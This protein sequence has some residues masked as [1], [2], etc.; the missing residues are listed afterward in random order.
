MEPQMQAWMIEPRDGLSFRDGRPNVGG[1]ESQSLRFPLPQTIAGAVRSRAGVDTE[2]R[3]D[4][5]QRESV[6]QLTIHGPLLVR[7]KGGRRERLVQAPQDALWEEDVNGQKKLH[8]LGPIQHDPRLR[9]GTAPEG[10][11]LVGLDVAPKG[12]PPKD[13][14]AFWTWEHLMAWLQSP[15]RAAGDLV[16]EIHKQGLGALVQEERVS[17]SIDPETNTYRHG[18]LFGVTSLLFRTAAHRLEE[19]SELGLCF[20][21][22]AKL[23]PGFGYLGGKNKL[24]TFSQEDS[25]EWP[26]TCPFEAELAKEERLRVLLLT[27]GIFKEGWSPTRLLEPSGGL[28]PIL[29]AAK[30]DRPETISGWDYEHQQTKGTRRLVGAG[31][32][33]WL[34]LGGTEEQRRQWIRDWWMQPVSDKDEDCRDGFGLAVMGVWA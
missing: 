15:A 10:L 30:V 21:T 19:V 31:A 9:G 14:P 28:S 20:R 22:D 25:P 2:G 17:V 4:V 7:I 29:K 13:V 34:E 27:P 5:S 16:V 6:K 32:V 12:K 33:Y 3:F 23:E 8:H 18:A 1:S 24:A 11:D 26:V